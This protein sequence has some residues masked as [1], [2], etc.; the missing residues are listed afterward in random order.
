MKAASG[1]AR[2]Q[3]EHEE[4]DRRDRPAARRCCAASARPTKAI[5][6]VLRTS[7]LASNLRASAPPLTPAAVSAALACRRVVELP[8]ISAARAPA[9]SAWLRPGRSSLSTPSC[10]KRSAGETWRGRARQSL[11]CRLDHHVAV[12]R[13]RQGARGTPT[14]SN[15]GR[16]LLKAEELEADVGLAADRDRRHVLGELLQHLRIAA[17]HRRGSSA[18]RASACRAR[19]PR[20]GT[21]RRPRAGPSSAPPNA[22]RSARAGSPR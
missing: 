15:G 17:E 18:R 1:I 16:R 3:P 19:L 20:S 14:S 11:P 5:A 10:Q 21:M 6:T 2:H 4:Q 7:R 12:D 22:C 8:P 13:R 9:G